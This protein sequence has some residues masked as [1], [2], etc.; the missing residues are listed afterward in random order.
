MELIVTRYGLHQVVQA[1]FDRY[2]NGQ[3]ALQLVTEQDEP[4][5]T[6]SCAIDAPIPAGCI[7]VKDWSE[8]EGVPSLL[9]RCGIIDG[10]PVARARSGFVAVP[11]YR[12]TAAALR[13]AAL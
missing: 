1:R 11:I 2:R 9:A 12:L 13:E 5:L 8:N 7:A 10:E 4:W 3:I 6:A